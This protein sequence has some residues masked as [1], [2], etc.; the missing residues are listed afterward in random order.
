ML[1]DN[2][3]ADHPTPIPSPSSILQRHFHYN[4]K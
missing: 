4:D 3:I 2:I 1:L